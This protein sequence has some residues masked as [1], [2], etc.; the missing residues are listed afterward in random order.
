M[1]STRIRKFIKKNKIGKGIKANAYGQQKDE[2]IKKMNAIIL[3][4][5]ENKNYVQKYITTTERGER[6]THLYIIHR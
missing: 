2:R 4:K 3:H 6:T 5:N 1:A